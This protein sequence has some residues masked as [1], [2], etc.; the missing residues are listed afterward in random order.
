MATHFP[1]VDP[2]TEPILELFRT[3]VARKRAQSL[4]DFDD[5]LLGWRAL[6]ANPQLGPAMA[7]RWDHVLVDEYQDVNQIQVDIVNL[8]CPDGTGLT[9]VGDDAQAVY[10]FRGSVSGTSCACPTR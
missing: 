10:G 3:Y 2:E 8:L 5:L 6:L 4:L 7:Q 1:W 9:V